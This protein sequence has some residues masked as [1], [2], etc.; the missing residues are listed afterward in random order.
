MDSQNS[1]LFNILFLISYFFI[2]FFIKKFDRKFSYLDI[3]FF[4]WLFILLTVQT[5][6]KIY[7]PYTSTIFIFY[8]AGIFFFLGSLALLILFRKTTSKEYNYNTNK[9]KKILG[10]IL[11]LSLV[12]NIQY[13]LLLK[14]VGVFNS[15]LGLLSLRLPQVRELVDQSSSILFAFFGRCHYIYI[16]IAFLLYRSRDISLVALVCIVLFAFLVNGIEFTRAPLLSVTIICLTSY[17]LFL[18]IT[19]KTLVVSSVF[20]VLFFAFVSFISQQIEDKV[21]VEKTTDS[22]FQLYLFG[23][24]KAYENILSDH[25]DKGKYSHSYYSLDFAN[26]PLKRLGLIESYPSIVREY[27]ITPPTNVY[28]FLDAFTLDFGVIGAYCGTFI[29]GFLMAFIYKKSISKHL[30]YMIIYGSCCYYI[31]MSPLNNEFIRFGFVIIIAQAFVIER[32]S[33][34]KM[35]VHE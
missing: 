10:V 7:A 21:T 29:L 14:S 18:K 4:I 8:I 31:A 28:T 12:A 13:F 34:E 17:L 15:E 2:Y 33:R 1:I 32:L 24:I 25:Y 23:G 19:R 22:E 16:P 6:F 3:F 35:S 11:L 30:A 26:Y 9:L 5:F 20:F 27:S